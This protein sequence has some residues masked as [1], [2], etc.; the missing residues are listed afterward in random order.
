[1]SDSRVQIN[2]TVED[3]ATP[4]LAESSGRLAGLTC[5]HDGNELVDWE[6]PDAD[7][8]EQYQYGENP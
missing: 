7:C 1:M 6:C 3:H 8:L 2:A 4:K 5:E